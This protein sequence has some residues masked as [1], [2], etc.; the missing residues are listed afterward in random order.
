[1]FSTTRSR[2]SGSTASDDISLIH[3]STTLL[4]RLRKRVTVAPAC[5]LS[6]RLCIVRLVAMM[7]PWRG[8]KLDFKKKNSIGSFGYALPRI[9]FHWFLSYA[10]LRTNFYWAMRSRDRFSWLRV[11]ED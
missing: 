11:V 9:N 10:L 8:E 3:S 1:M 5:C 2:I 4:K 7:E 6:S